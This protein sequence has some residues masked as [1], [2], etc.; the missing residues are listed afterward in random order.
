MA[1]KIFY[2]SLGFFVLV[3]IFLGAYNFAF[4][5]NVNNPIVDAS[6]Q[7]A[8]EKD[9][10]QALGTNS[11]IENPLNERVMGAVSSSD[12]HLYYYSFD[13][14]SIKKA[15]LEGKDKE[16][17]LSN[18]PGN[19][20]RILWSPKRDKVL[21]YIKQ[22]SGG[23]LWYS[24]DILRKTIAP[25][26]PEISRLAWDNL[27]EKI[28]YL[29]TD[30]RGSRTLNIANADGGEW[31][32]IADLGSTEVFVAAVPQSS[33]V[34][35]WNRPLASTP[36]T[37]ETVTLS[38]E[39][40]KT[41]FSGKFGADYV[42]APNGENVLLSAGEESNSHAPSLSLVRVTNGEVRTLG[43]PTF[44]NKVVWSK[45]NQ[46]LYYA[47]PVDLPEDAIL[48]DDYFA[49]NLHSKD[50]FWKI[51]IGTGKKTRLV[52]L[53]ETN[54]DLDSTDLFLSP[55]ED[56]LYFTDRKSGMLHRIEL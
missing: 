6:K 54:K 2:F 35:F 38:G 31:K 14:Q 43:V 1:K 4:K 49:K 51:D 22:T 52:N 16:V 42:W 40:R 46:T 55:N 32:K 18:L 33:T 36:S 25:L 7:N 47:L 9:A 3:L 34:S 26:K 45:D 19:P 12:N 50:T 44:I 24:A 48:P 29:F 21:L 37:L 39:N 11:K 53:S 15:T 5:N 23:Y 41:L 10:E 56:F 30:S 20:S 28:F 17:L 8:S 27:G 13:D